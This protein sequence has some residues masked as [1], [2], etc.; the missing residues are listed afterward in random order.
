MNSLPGIW[1]ATVRLNLSDICL[2]RV[3]LENFNGFLL[4]NLDWDAK[5]MDDCFLHARAQSADFVPDIEQLKPVERVEIA[6]R[7]NWRL[8]VENYSECYHCQ[9]NHRAFAQ[10]IVKASTY[11]ILLKAIVYDIQPSARI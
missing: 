3:R 8:S 9:L 7:C 6:E 10:G 2:T 1:S 11:D 4:A 5:T